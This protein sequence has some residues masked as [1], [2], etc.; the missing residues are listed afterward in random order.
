MFFDGQLLEQLKSV[1]KD[2]DRKIVFK[3]KK[4]GHDKNEELISFLKEFAT[5]SQFFSLYFSEEASDYPSFDIYDGVNFSGV[6]FSA[7]PGGH[8]FNSFVLSILNMIGKG[9]FPDDLT[10]Q[11]I[12]SLPEKI[13]VRTYVSLSCENCPDVV[14]VLNMISILHG[15]MTHEMVDGDLALDEVRKLNIQGVPCVLVDGKMISSGKIGLMDLLDKIF[16]F[17]NIK[18]KLTSNKD[19][20]NFDVVVVGGGPAGSSAA[21]YS[22]RKGKNTVV[23]TERIGGQVRDTLGIQNFISVNNTEGAILSN[24]LENHMSEYGIKVLENRRVER[25]EKIDKLTKVV[26]TSGEFLSAKSL[27]V[28]T[29]AK[30]RELNVPGEK[31]FIGKGVAFCPHC[32]GPYYKNKTVVVVGGGNSGVEAAIDLSNICKKVTLLE[33]NDNLKADSYLIDKLKSIGNISVRTGVR[34]KEISGEDK[35]DSIIVERREDGIEE[36]IETDGV[37]VQIGL[38]ANSGFLKGSLELNKFGE[39]IIDEKCRTS[40]KGVYAA[41]DVTTVPYKQI[42][43]AMGEGA[44]AALTAFEDSLKD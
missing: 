20:G 31:K 5:S 4:S 39:I 24:N 19:L 41:G 14:Q 44:K 23:I 16:D 7:I 32:D 33:Y 13:H 35:V 21:I 25:I 29:G 17:Y 22:A 9:K 15:S 18:P 8:E 43:I 27:I 3:I 10:I 38:A 26:L 2:L 34:T 1:F 42:I 12:K 36:K 11:K 28:A 40:M 6:R 37:F 30:W